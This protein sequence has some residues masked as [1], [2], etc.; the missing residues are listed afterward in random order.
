MIRYH[1][2]VVCE[3]DYKSKPQKHSKYIINLFFTAFLGLNCNPPPK[4]TTNDEIYN[5]VKIASAIWD[6]ILIP[7][8]FILDFLITFIQSIFNA[9]ETWDAEINTNLFSDDNV[10]TISRV[11]GNRFDGKN[12]ISWGRLR[13]GVIAMATVWYN[14][15]T[16][17][18]VEFGIVFNTAYTWGID[19][20]GEGEEYYL[21]NA[22][23]VQNIATHEAGH[24][25]MLLDLYIPEANVLTM[26]GYGAYGETYAMSL[27][28]GDISGIRYIYN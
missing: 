23:D 12:V 18:I 28:D 5:L 7:N 10:E 20:D 16:S 3:L 4:T 1:R 25:L 2:S 6:K 21:G 17:E 26:Y 15:D 13:R 19:A 27:G 9:F 8:N 22:F 11:K 24:T 14:R